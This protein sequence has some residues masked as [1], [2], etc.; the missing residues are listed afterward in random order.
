MSQVSHST[1][2]TK[3]ASVAQAAAAVDV[4]VTAY[5][6][7]PAIFREKRILTLPE[8]KSTVAVA[9]LPQTFVPNSLTITGVSG[10]GKLTLGA[11]SYREPSLSLDAILKKA[12]GTTVSLVER[13]QVGEYRTSGKLLH[14]LNNQAVL[15]QANGSLLVV[16]MSDRI[17]L[18]AETLAGLTKTSS[19]QLEPTASRAA[20]YTVGILFAADGLSWNLNYEAFYDAAGEKLDRFACW[21]NLTNKSGADIDAAKIKLIFGANTGYEDSRRNR[22][23][24]PMMAMAAASPEGGGGGLESMSF[25]ADSAAVE[26]VGEQKLYTLPESLSIA[27]D[28]TKQTMLFLSEGVPVTP[29][30]YLN[31]T[32]YALDPDGQRTSANKLP[33]NVRLKLANSTANKLGLAL[34]PGS[35]KIFEADSS[36]SLQRTDSSRLGNHVAGNEEFELALNT[37]CKDLKA[38]R[39]ITFLREDPLPAPAPAPQPALTAGPSAAAPAPIKEEKPPRYREEEREIVFFNFKDK[40]VDIKVHD[41][42][43]HDAEYIK[44]L[45]GVKSH[46]TSGGAAAFTVSVPKNGQA[47]RAYRIKYRIG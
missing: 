11:L 37:P 20:D 21:V 36:G 27:Q 6:Q 24:R 31:Y 26:S 40:D 18:L 46:A 4:K 12:I 14:V 2:Q 8:G 43:P 25:G 15:E 13:T 35:V 23:A 32:G 34:P 9:G 41:A 22:A 16:P 33:V 45:V 29:E 10:E 30:Y 47:T 39:R 19:L 7:G 42:V 1:K 28:E 3:P 38:T 44:A 17:D 5:T